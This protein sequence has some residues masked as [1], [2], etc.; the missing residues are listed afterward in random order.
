MKLTSLEEIETFLSPPHS[1][2]AQLA[3]RAMANSRLKD[4]FNINST[5]VNGNIDVHSIFTK[6]VLQQLPI[7][8]T[9]DIMLTRHAIQLISPRKLPLCRL[10]DIAKETVALHL[11]NIPAVASLDKVVR[12]I[13]IHVILLGLL[14]DYVDDS[15]ISTDDLDLVTNGINELWTLSKS[16]TYRPDLLKEVNERLRC[17]LPGYGNPLEII[18]PA[19]ETLWRVV[20]IAVSLGHDNRHALP[21][22]GAL[23]KQP[24]VEQ[25]REFANESFSADAFMQEVLRLYPPTRRI[26]RVVTVSS[27][28]ILGKI[29]PQLFT[30]KVAIAADVE[31][32]QRA[33]VWADSRGEFDP[34]RH[35]PQRCTE[36]Q[37]KTL[38][39]FGA[40]KLTCVA[41]NWAPQAAAVIVAAI[42]DQIGDEKGFIIEAGRVVGGRE[43]WDGWAIRRTNDLLLT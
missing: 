28:S 11:N 2:A 24:T 38:L 1:I 29:F 34:A 40:G 16:S 25:Y 6:Q 32:L 22:F 14:R 27:S 42:L 12:R 41:K 5:F 20:A 17:W 7:D 8:D 39:A 26:S 30:R 18:I 4:A 37:R 36:Q 9:A 23:L 3:S 35:H 43:G 31:A 15:A 13:T 33:D 19:Y 21:V 10:A